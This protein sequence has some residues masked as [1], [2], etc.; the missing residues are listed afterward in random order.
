[1]DNA[2]T[3]SKFAT[4][5]TTVSE[6]G[7]DGKVNQHYLNKVMGLAE[8][9]PVVSTEDIYDAHGMKLL[10]KGAVV[11]RVLQEKMILHKLKKPIE[12]CLIVEGG[13]NAN[14]LVAG[15]ERVMESCPP[16]ADVV[17]TIC[18][19]GFTPLKVL[20]NMAFGNA[21]T[22]MLTISERDRSNSFE[23][24][25]I[26]SM[27][28]ICWAR[29]MRLSEQDQQIAGLAGL[30]HDVGELYI[31]PAYL[32]RASHLL[33]HEWAHVV[34]HPRIGQMLIDECDSMPAGVGRAVAEHHE[35]FDGGGYPRRL[36]GRE[37]S[38]PGQIVA[39]S[40]LI[41]GLL[42]AD[43]PLERAELAI[44]ILPGEHE[45]GLLSAISGALHLSRLTPGRPTGAE[46]ATS[47]D[48]ESDELERLF[49]RLANSLEC[50][51]K[52]LEG[53]HAKSH[54]AR[55]ILMQTVDRIQ[56]I[57][58]AFV[59]TGMDVYLSRSSLFSGIADNVITFEKQVATRE[60]QWRLRGL[61]RDIALRTGTNDDHPIFASLIE[62][63]DDRTAA[64]AESATMH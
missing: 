17:R 15:A 43:R 37:I 58:R 47:D 25:L 19:G 62:M 38:L 24:A 60:I 42:T 49:E 27:L 23:H 21:M 2:P 31:D 16:L 59:S 20:A 22:M 33:P 34:V 48:L 63:L 28:S 11:S 14:T 61:A 7:L 32:S 30:L 5:Q 40:E 1:M 54:H 36:H 13:V 29:K 9:M 57:Q 51:R 45:H 8:V 35:R 50:S 26:V 3:L 41:A 64:Q 52:L 6:P 53:S 12:S 46:A 39:M 18:V 44:K 10:A 55:E 56:T 4:P